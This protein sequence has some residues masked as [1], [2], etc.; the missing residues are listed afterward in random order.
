MSSQRAVVRAA[1]AEARSTG[2]SVL[3]VLG[4]PDW[5]GGFGFEPAVPHGIA[6]AGFD[7]GAAFK[8][9]ALVPG[10]LAQARG[11]LAWHD[12]FAPLLAGPH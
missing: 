12:A 7:F 10:A 11:S 5:Y 2:A 9:M 3:T 1:I 8:V 4:D 6:V